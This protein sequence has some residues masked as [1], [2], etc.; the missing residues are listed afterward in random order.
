MRKLRSSSSFSTCTCCSTGP[1]AAA[2]SSTR[3]SSAHCQRSWG[4]P[5]CG[6]AG[7]G[8]PP[9][10]AAA[11]CSPAGRG[12]CTSDRRASYR[13]AVRST[14]A[15]L[16]TSTTFTPAG[17]SACRGNGGEGGVLA[18]GGDRAGAAVRGGGRAAAAVARRVSGQGAAAGEPSCPLQSAA[19]WSQ[20]APRAAPSRRRP[21]W[22]CLAACTGCTRPTLSRCEWICCS[23]CRTRARCL[24]GG[25]GGSGRRDEMLLG[26]LQAPAG[27]W[28]RAWALG[29]SGAGLAPGHKRALRS[30]VRRC[31][32]WRSA[33]RPPSASRASAGPGHP[34]AHRRHVR[35]CVH[36]PPR[37]AS[38]S[39]WARCKSAEHSPVLSTSSAAST[40][41]RGAC[42]LGSSAWA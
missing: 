39:P 16:A 41:K 23:M 7:C 4:R 8:C 21:A 36:T 31:R 24:A 42:W 12:T 3:S 15:P 33:S 20:P 37:A 17:R 29:A 27:G 6:C 28:Q 2:G 30:A 9:G 26:M 10:A 34:T 13:P 5:G 38:A 32:C 19:R 40:G 14:T 11:G 18:R 22:P 35:G 1:L 25:S